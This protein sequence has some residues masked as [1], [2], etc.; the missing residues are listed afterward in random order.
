MNGTV[1]G[2]EERV[3]VDWESKVG[4]QRSERHWKSTY[5]V[6]RKSN[7]KSW[8][9]SSDRMSEVGGAEVGIGSRLL[10]NCRTR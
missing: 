1:K 5:G 9:K 2:D 6:V 4:I 3:R 7:R 10:V 8:G